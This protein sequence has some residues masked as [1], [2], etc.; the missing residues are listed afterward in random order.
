MAM[1][2]MICRSCSFMVPSVQNQRLPCRCL[3]TYRHRQVMA[4]DKSEKNS[5]GRKSAWRR[6]WKRSSRSSRSSLGRHLLHLGGIQQPHPLAWHGVP[7]LARL[8]QLPHADH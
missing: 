4:I 8:A 1:S 3:E 5:V 6:A 7:Q 2:M